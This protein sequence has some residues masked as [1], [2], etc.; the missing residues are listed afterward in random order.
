MLKMAEL[1]APMKMTYLAW[2][3]PARVKN[4]FGEMLNIFTVG[5][6]R[7]TSATVVFTQS[8]TPQTCYFKNLPRKKTISDAKGILI[9][10][11]LCFFNQNGN[12]TQSEEGF[13]LHLSLSA[14]TASALGRFSCCSHPLGDPQLMRLQHSAEQ[15]RG[16]RDTQGARK[17]LPASLSPSLPPAF[18][19]QS[20]SGLL[21]S[22]RSKH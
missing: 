14:G 10:S 8:T 7:T 4:L 13:I 22:P 20:L 1:C 9:I 17:Q 18:T 6:I 5:Q 2:Q 3:T 21:L 11:L 15:K 19:K 16:R 12:R